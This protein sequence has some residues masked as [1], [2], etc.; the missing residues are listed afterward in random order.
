MTG[1]TKVKQAVYL[2]PEIWQR[3]FL[4]HT[5]PDSLWTVGR[6]VC[7]AWRS[8]IVKVFAKKYL[9]DPD[10]VQVYFNCGRTIIEGVNCMMGV[11]MVFDR[12]AGQAN[13]RRVF[14]Q[15]PTTGR[16]TS[17]NSKAFN[18]QCDR[19]KFG[20]WQRHIEMYLGADPGARDDGGRFDLPPNQVRM[21]S[22]ANDSEL[23]GLEY[24][25]RKREISFEWE[26]MF[27]NFYREVAMLAK[28][29]HSIITEST[30]W[31][32]GGDTSIAG[33]LA[34]SKRNKETR[35]SCAKEIRRDRIEKLYLENHDWEFKE[36]LL[37][38]E[39]ENKT[40]E[41]IE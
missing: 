24:N 34:L 18:E 1:D 35:R 14:A 36:S 4:Q 17:R 32:N 2:P 20:A 7:S 9:E 21:K 38:E 39:E 40:L 22:K 15:S 10:M 30:Q 23:P 25:L 19:T 6:R 3:V 29:E 41:A 8:E 37:E 28:R 16:R 26:G 5:D 31:L 12:Y 33:A 11:E 13:S 27:A